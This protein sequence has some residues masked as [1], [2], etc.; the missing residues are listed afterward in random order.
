MRYLQVRNQIN[1]TTTGHAE[2]LQKLLKVNKVKC[3]VG[4]TIC[5]I[6]VHITPSAYFKPSITYN[7]PSIITR[8]IHTKNTVKYE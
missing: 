1:I 2:S 4:E 3:M 8:S 6:K 7:I 5:L